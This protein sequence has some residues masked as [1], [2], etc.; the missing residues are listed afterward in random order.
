MI[1]LSGKIEED[2]SRLEEA[3]RE[4][5]LKAMNMTESGLDQL[6]REG[7][8]LLKLISFFTVGE[9]ENRAW[10]V[11]K[12]SSAPQAAGKIHSDF[13]KGFIRAEVVA[14]DAFVRSRGWKEA[15]EQGLSRAEGRDYVMADGDV[16]LFRFNV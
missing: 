15:R 9:T 13:E 3:E 16:V 7:H 4:E 8:K 5:F 1:V 6:A 2:I 11:E 14:F 12:G 10:D